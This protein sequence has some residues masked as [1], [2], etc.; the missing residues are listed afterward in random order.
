M[1]AYKE[2]EIR[3]KVQIFFEESEPI[4][5]LYKE[6]FLNY[7]GKTIDTGK[8]YAEVVADE[9]VKNYH[10]VSGPW[11]IPIRRTKQ[12]NLHHDG[13][14]N[15]KSRINKYKSLKYCEKLLAIALYNSGQP[16]CLGKIKD[17]EIPLKE[18]RSDEHN[19]GKIDLISRD[20]DN[21]SVRLIELKIKNDRGTDETLLRAVL[22]IY[23]YFKLIIGSKSQDKLLEEYELPKYN[24]LQPA[25]ITDELALSGQQLLQIKEKYPHLKDLISS[26]NNEIGEQI[27]GYVYDYPARGKPF[28]GN[29]Q[30]SQDSYQKIMLQGNITIRK[31]I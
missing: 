10:K 23:T 29:A 31:I 26:I 24:R 3:R 27:E 13:F 14:S 5:C 16:Y 12:F 11:N 6:K 9:L 30:D 22:E 15:V 7:L 1:R 18:E 2:P 28:Q 20:D 25:I 4:E 8:E 19:L 17:Y 21:R